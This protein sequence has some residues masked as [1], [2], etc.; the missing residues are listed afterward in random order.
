MPVIF[1][2]DYGQDQ[3]ITRAFGP[4]GA[5]DY[6]VKPFSSTELAACIQAALRRRTAPQRVEPP[7]PYELGDFAIDCVHRWVTV[8][9]GT[10][11]SQPPNMACWRSCR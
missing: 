10:C 11:S 6:V 3:V 9:G 2:S 1:L 8:V 7:E 4:C 5:E